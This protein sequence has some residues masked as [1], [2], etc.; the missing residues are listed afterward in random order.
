MIPFDFFIH[1]SRLLTLFGELSEE[2]LKRG[3]YIVS[4]INNDIIFDFSP[5]F[6]LPSLNGNV[7]IKDKN[8]RIALYLKFAN[9]LLDGSCSITFG[10]FLKITG[11]WEKGIRN[12]KFEETVMERVIFE[13][14]YLNDMRNGICSVL[15]ND[16]GTELKS[17][18]YQNG[19]CSNVQLKNING[20]N[21]SV[22]YQNNVITEIREMSRDSSPYCVLS[23]SPES[24]ELVSLVI[25]R[26]HQPYRPLI[27]FNGK[28]MKVFD[29]GGR[30]VYH[31]GYFYVPPFKFSVH[32]SG[33]QYEQFRLVYR[34]DFV[35][36]KREGFGRYFYSNGVSKYVGN[37]KN[38]LPHGPGFICNDRGS[39]VLD[40]TCDKGTFLY[41]LRKYTVEEFCPSHIFMKLFFKASDEHYKYLNQYLP[42]SSQL[43]EETIHLPV[44]HYP[45]LRNWYTDSLLENNIEVAR[46]LD[47]F[48]NILMIH[49][50]R[51][52]SGLT[53]LTLNCPI[54][55][56]YLNLFPKL[57]S[58]T[59]AKGFSI[60]N[61]LVI[62]YCPSL[63]SLCFEPSSG[64]G[65]SCRSL[66]IAH[67]PS[68]LTLTIGSC[69]LQYITKLS[70]IGTV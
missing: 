15:N 64:N 31:G 27:S 6:S 36:G 35:H 43:L 20:Y 63:K 25:W 61:D 21:V 11:Y 17:I 53:V 50:Y 45:K 23:M 16:K 39:R 55:S 29:S 38:D 37:W 30:M 48:R 5:V 26:F 42:S 14:C 24:G 67:C 34:G 12:G 28:Q 19:M 54:P 52:L 10:G 22:N 51:E 3:N 47:S 68:L 57:E 49:G 1:K 8:G 56:L 70:I 7:T 60:P 66:S 18:D 32:G 58:L 62:D 65:T 4:F 41:G 46:K 44:L 9:S 13:G 69:S 59:F 2:S 40:V 33:E